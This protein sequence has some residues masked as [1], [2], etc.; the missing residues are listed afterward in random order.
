MKYDEVLKRITFDVAIKNHKGAA[1]LDRLENIEKLIS[2][3]SETIPSDVSF[4][5]FLKYTDN[6]S[7]VITTNSNNITLVKALNKFEMYII[8]LQN[9]FE[10]KKTYLI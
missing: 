4:K 9:G 5:I 1:I 6:T 3:E 8:V 2:S 7:E 10:S